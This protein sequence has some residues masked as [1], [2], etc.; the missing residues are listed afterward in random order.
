MLDLKELT[1]EGMAEIR[2]FLDF[3]S[4]RSCDLTIGGLYMWRELFGQLYAIRGDM[5]I[6]TAEYF[7][8]GRCYSYPV[9][10]GDFGAAIAAIRAD[11]R[12][13]GIP[14]RFCCIPEEGVGRLTEAVGRSAETTEYRDWA[15]YLYP[16]S[17][18]L[19]YH[20][21]KLVTQR[22]HCNRFRRDYPQYEYM[23]LT[24]ALIPEVRRFITDNIGSFM[25][26]SPLSKEDYFRTLELLDH[27]G[28]F[29]FT[30]GVLSVDGAVVGVTIGE[31]VGDTLFVHVEKALTSYSGAYPMLASLY[32]T[33]MARDGLCYI[34]REDDSGDPG[35]RR[36]KE[37]YRPCALIKK[38][39]LDFGYE[40]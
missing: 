3:Q 9:G 25:K 22:N 8:K 39:V 31:T 18:F 30:G 40:E 14:L 1:A 7:E 23:P 5:L 6:G 4:F 35:L 16:Y 38:Y 37:E 27:I 19:G 34:N 32:A 2:P 15:D 33:Q 24:D 26:D 36:S 10:S 29:G 28:Q 12:E 17:N 13:R 21:K 20:G 11:A